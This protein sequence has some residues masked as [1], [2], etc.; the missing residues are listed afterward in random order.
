MN[1]R[2]L[3]I[4]CT[5]IML[6]SIVLPG[7]L[8][9]TACKTGAEL[10]K[11]GIG[12]YRYKAGEVKKYDEEITLTFGRPIDFNATAYVTMAEKGEPVTDNRW[13]RLYRDA[14][15]VNAVYGLDNASGTDYN[16]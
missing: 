8:A 14:V 16:Q 9:E 15:N 12:E 11:E 10:Y 13:I 3:A 4:L 5:A 7:A 6:M 2:L 1:K